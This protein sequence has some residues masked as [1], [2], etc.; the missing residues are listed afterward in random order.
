MPTYNSNHSNIAPISH[1]NLIPFKNILKQLQDKGWQYVY[2]ADTYSD[3]V[4]NNICSNKIIMNKK[5]H[6]LEEICIEYKNSSYHITLPINNSIYSYYKH[7]TNIHSS[8]LFL[9]NYIGYINY[10]DLQE[11]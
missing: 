3:V 7:F 2:E 9:I 4:D 5:Y 6:E 1:D 8:I 10:T 11:K